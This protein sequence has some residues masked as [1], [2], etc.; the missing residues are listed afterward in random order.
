MK[1]F[2]ILVAYITASGHIDTTIEWFDMDE[3]TPSE[4]DIIRLEN[5]LCYKVISVTVLRW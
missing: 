4:D 2:K 1:S 5:N 3:D